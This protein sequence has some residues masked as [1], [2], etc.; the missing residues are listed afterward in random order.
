[1]KQK[2]CSG[3]G[4]KLLDFGQIL[5]VKPT[6]YAKRREQNTITGAMS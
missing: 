4:K 6:A 2:Q 5:K 3:S 1:M